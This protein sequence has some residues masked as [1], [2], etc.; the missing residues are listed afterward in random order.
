MDRI[1]QSYMET[2]LASQQ[3]TEKEQ[4]KQFE[5]FASYCAIEQHY[6]DTYNLSDI[7]TADGGDCGIDA[8]AII[9]N[10]TMII[11]EE[12]IDDLLELNKNLSD[13]SFVF[14]QAKTSSNFDYSEIGT[15]GAG[16]KDF[17]SEH[18]Q[19]IRNDLIKEKC[20]LVEHIFSKAT[21]IKKKPTCYLY[22]ITTGKW[23]NDENCMGRMQIAKNDLLDLNLFEAV[24][25]TSIG[26]DQLQKMYRNSI[27]AIETEINFEHKILLPEIQN[28]TQSYLGFISSDEYL[29]LI[30]NEKGDIRK[31]VFYDNVRDY[32]GDN[33]VNHEM[34]ETVK[35]DSNKFVLFNNGVTV[36]CKGLT[37]IRNKFTL[38]D[39]QIV[40]Q[41]HL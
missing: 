32:Q 35:S 18:P 16:V 41:H 10:G 38:I 34:T 20:K 40:N 36:I 26:A 3:I 4:S 21:R 2:F 6:S 22:F 1:I 7:I 14:I 13:I 24:E 8:I 15:F 12:E 37:N 29:K 25:Y 9:V 19:M 11:S 5:L 33:P 23:M 39:Y 30:T 17:F 28:V 31:S 27:D